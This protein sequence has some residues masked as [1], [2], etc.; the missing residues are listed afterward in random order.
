LVYLIDSF[1]LQGKYE[2][3]LRRVGIQHEGPSETARDFPS[4]SAE[5]TN[6]EVRTWYFGLRRGLVKYLF[7]L[8][9][10][11]NFHMPHG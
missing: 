3:G 1:Q 9:V 10:H 11:S 5:D 6:I 2:E 7:I 4:P 8:F